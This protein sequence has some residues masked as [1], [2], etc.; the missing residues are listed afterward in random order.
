MK[1]LV[2]TL[3]ASMIPMSAIPMAAFAQ[4]PVPACVLQGAPGVSQDTVQQVIAT[5]QANL[6]AN[7]A[8]IEARFQADSRALA[9]GADN[10]AALNGLVAQFNQDM[11]Q[12]PVAYKA[13]L[14]NRCAAVGCHVMCQ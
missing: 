8:R 7:Q 6:K 13:E 10:A 11:A 14:A 3:V 2:L 5:A 12:T 1:R 9:G 4:P